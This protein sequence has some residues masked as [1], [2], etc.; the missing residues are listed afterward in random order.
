MIPALA[1]IAILSPRQSNCP[2]FE[3]A[4]QM[5]GSWD[6]GAQDMPLH[7]E[8]HLSADG[9][10]LEGDGTL[11][12]PAKPILKMHSRMGVDS[13]SGKLYYLDCHNSDTVYFGLGEVKDGD[14]YLDFRAIVG[15]PGHFA[16]RDRISKDSYKGTVYGFKRDGTLKELHGVVM[17]RSK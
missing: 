14:V 1:V 11:G 8:Y 16:S 3:L 12:D 13:G 2:A 9:A 5:M 17:K 6:G 7:F 4:K 10:C 15:G